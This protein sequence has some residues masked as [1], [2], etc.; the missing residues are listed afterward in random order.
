MSPSPPPSRRVSNSSGRRRS[1]GPYDPATG[2]W[3]PGGVEPGTTR[4]LRLAARVLG[5]GPL[6]F[7]M[8]IAAAD[9]SDT[10][11]GNNTAVVVVTATPRLVPETP[12]PPAATA[13]LGG[14]ISRTPMAMGS[15]RRENLGSVA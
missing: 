5:A 3:T 6:T 7:T 9:Q 11:P 8:A 4:V 14:Q 15:G 10:D 13:S 1:P 2:T 12:R